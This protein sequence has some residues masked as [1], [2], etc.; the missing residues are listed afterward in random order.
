M[1]D[2]WGPI[3]D[4]YYGGSEGFGFCNI[5]ADE[6]LEHGDV[7]SASRVLKDDLRRGRVGDSREIHQALRQRVTNSEH[8]RIIRLT[9]ESIRPGVDRLTRKGI[10]QQ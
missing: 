4:E 6:W 10:P 3:V 8:V 1:I 5:R 9:R 7:L 2:W